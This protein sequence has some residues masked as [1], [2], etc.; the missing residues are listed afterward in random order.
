MQIKFIT[1][2]LLFCSLFSQKVIAQKKYKPYNIDYNYAIGEVF[3]YNDWFEGNKGRTR[4]LILALNKHTFGQK[5]WERTYNYP[6]YGLTFAYQNNNEGFLGDVYSL[7][8]HYTHYFYKR[9]LSIRIADGISFASN[10]YDKQTNSKNIFIS[11][12]LSNGFIATLQWREENLWKDFGFQ[13]GATLSHY[14]NGRIKYRNKGLNSLFVQAGINYSFGKQEQEFIY[15]GEAEPLDKKLHYNFV[16]RG[17][18]NENS[19]QNAYD[20]FCTLSFYLDKRLDKMRAIE[21]GLD[22]F[23]SERFKHH[24]QET[25]QANYSSKRVGMFLGHD[26]ILNKLSI[27]ILLGYYLYNP[28]KYESM[29]YQ[30]V[31]AKYALTKHVFATV[32]VKLHINKAENLEFGLGLK[33]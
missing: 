20:S 14:S 31:G 30:R 13:I 15:E 27:P 18:F 2:I 24:L 28:S 8:L 32:S 1:F 26:L 17:G 10:P 25:N 5:E 12:P 22:Y 6:S 7:M 3:P 29:F 19:A 16:C 4:N 23:T 21:L 11:S 9:K 33:L